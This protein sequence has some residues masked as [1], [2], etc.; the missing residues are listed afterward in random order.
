MLVD[1]DAAAVISPAA[2]PGVGTVVNG[3]TVWSESQIVTN[4]ERL[5]D[6][7]A[8][9]APVITYQFYDSQPA[10]FPSGSTFAP[11]SAD[12]RSLARQAFAEWAAVA[13]VTFVEAADNGVYGG[14]T[15]RV[16]L[17][18]NSSAPSYEWGDTVT[19]TRGRR[20]RARRCRAVRSP[21]TRRRSMRAS[22]SSAA[23]TS[24]R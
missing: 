13:N 2:E 12:E 5:N 14:T 10:G 7:W 11:L 6:K 23:T 15:Q 8:G 4:F 9:A 19:Y 20:A 17:F 3:K 16:S 1:D 22:C 18:L 21:S 24:R